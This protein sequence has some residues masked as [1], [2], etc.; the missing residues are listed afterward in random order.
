MA[1]Y[2]LASCIET[3]NNREEVAGMILI[4]NLYS[5]YYKLCKAPHSVMWGEPFTR[6][7]TGRSV[8][9]L[10]PNLS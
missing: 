9:V 5:L 8:V 2:L 3:F 10:T 4:Q 6:D 1:V 7:G